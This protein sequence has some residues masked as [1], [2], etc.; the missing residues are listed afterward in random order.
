MMDLADTFEQGLQQR[1][2]IAGRQNIPLDYM[3]QILAKFKQAQLI[4]STRGRAGGV[5]LKK[6]PS[7]ISLWE[8]LLAAEDNMHPVKCLEYEGCDW[9]ARCISV[10]AW[11]DVYS[12]I[13][14]ELSKKSLAE[15]VE[16]WK[17]KKQNLPPS[18][19]SNLVNK[20]PQTHLADS[21]EQ[22]SKCCR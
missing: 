19:L 5:Q 13:R 11:N 10:E 14:K 7:E 17:M 16:N 12:I 18:L 3:D 8:I 4:K 1:H 21:L 6:A 9:E 15:L 22:K 20:N 2:S